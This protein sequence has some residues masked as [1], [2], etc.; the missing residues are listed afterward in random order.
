MKVP[1]AVFQ[2]VEKR[3]VTLAI[4]QGF[5]NLLGPTD[6]STV[7]AAMDRDTFKN[8]HPDDI[9]RLG[10]AVAHFMRYGGRL[11]CVYR[12]KK[13][14]ESGYLIIHAFGE[15]IYTDTGIRLGQIWFADEG[16]YGE[17]GE[18]RG[19][20]L[21]QSLSNA[22]HENSIVR[23]SYFAWPWL[24]GSASSAAPCVHH[25]PLWRRISPYTPFLVQYS[26]PGEAPFPISR[27][28]LPFPAGISSWSR[29]ASWGER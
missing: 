26:L 23:T 25:I 17:D 10:N 1:F 13:H 28:S 14:G 15:H 29:S 19:S 6:K 7:Y 9:A 8:V 24:T 11:E 5:C 3:I 4:S 18:R 12:L 27:C 22:L 2:L 20:Q 21:N 16:T